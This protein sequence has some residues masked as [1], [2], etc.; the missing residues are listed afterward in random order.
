MDIIKIIEN[1]VIK[2]SN[3]F[4]KEHS[5]NFWNIHIK[6]VV[7]NAIILAKKYNADVEIVT[8]AALLHDIASITKEEYQ[9]NHEIIGADI[10]EKLLR[11]N[12]Y[13][14]DKIELVKRCILNH[15]GSK[16]V[17]KGTI[18]EICVAD[19]D[20]LAHFNNVPTLFSLAYNKNKLSIEDGKIFV[21]EKLARSYNKL[22]NQTKKDYEEK[23]K[24]IL[25]II[26]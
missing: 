21:K 8:L 6:F 4:E 17:K 11:D 18:E 9:E 26:S 2:R 15:R 5:Y 22:S 12:N 1:E 7:E 23:Y 19:A 14:K 13:P 10:A 20:A 25:G 16:I 24:S 3:K